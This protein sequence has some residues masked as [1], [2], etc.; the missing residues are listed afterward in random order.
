MS[1]SVNASS[2]CCL[3]ESKMRTNERS[4]RKNIMTCSCAVLS[5]IR[6]WSASSRACDVSSKHEIWLNIDIYYTSCIHTVKAW[7]EG[8]KKHLVDGSVSLTC[9]RLIF[10]QQ[11]VALGLQLSHLGLLRLA[12]VF[13]WLFCVFWVVLLFLI[14]F[15]CFLREISNTRITLWFV[16]DDIP[17]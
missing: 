11:I 14:G 1:A 10:F 7:S 12:R 4:E 15:E 8:K 2:F 13:R 16:R 6:S 3:G 9:R 17:L 5:C